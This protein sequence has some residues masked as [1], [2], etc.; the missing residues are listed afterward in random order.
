MSLIAYSN[1]RYSIQAW[2]ELSAQWSEVIVND[3]VVAGVPIYN[4]ATLGME[5]AGGRVVSQ[6]ISPTPQ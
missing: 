5:R 1:I 3:P 6:W 4:G 2:D